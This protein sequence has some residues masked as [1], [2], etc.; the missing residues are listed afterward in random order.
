MAEPKKFL[1]FPNSYNH[2]N[3]ETAAIKDSLSGLADFTNLWNPVNL[4][5]T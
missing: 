2:R 4:C 5:Q 1:Y 3:V